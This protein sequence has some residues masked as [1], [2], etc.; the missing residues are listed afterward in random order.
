MDNRAT[1]GNLRELPLSFLLFDLWNLKKNGK[2]I[3]KQGKNEK[4]LFFEEGNIALTPE[5]LNERR[6]F[7]FLTERTVIQPSSLERILA[8]AEQEHLSLV[9]A[10]IEKDMVPTSDLWRL[11]QEYF[12]S[13][14]FPFFDRD[15]AQFLF[16]PDNKPDK[17][18]IWS[19]MLTLDV[20]LQGTRQMKNSAFIASLLPEAEGEAHALFPQHQAQISF[21]PHEDYLLHLFTNLQNLKSVYNQTETSIRETQKAIFAF[22]SLGL[23]TFSKTKRK[24]H[25]LPDFSQTELNTILTSFNRKWLFAF[26][27]ISKELGPVAQNILEKSL[28]EAKTR[29]SPLFQSVKLHPD[30]TIDAHS[31]LKAKFNFSSQGT[32][33]TLLLGLNEIIVSEV[34]AVKKTLGDEHEATLVQNLHKIE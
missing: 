10:C 23:F 15:D 29:L 3:L 27:Y 30:G 20:I 17:M 14:I 16:Q 9:K 22:L 25:S 6:F 2:L 13:D 18:K 28:D 32:K 8:F 26:K 5:T 33:Q 19:R 21:E 31:V 24:K 34:Q 4:I 11:M 1:F 12:L 7:S